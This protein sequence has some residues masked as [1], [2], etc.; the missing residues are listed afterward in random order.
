MLAAVDNPSNA[1]EWALAEM[2]NN[3]ELL[4]MVVEDIDR[5]V[6]RERF[7]QETDIL[8]LNYT[9]ARIR[10]AMRLHHVVPFNVPHIALAETTI[11]G[12]RVPKGSHVL[13]SR[14]DNPNVWDKAKRFKPERHMRGDVDVV[15]TESELRF[16][17][18]STGRRGCI[19]ISLGTAMSIML[20][21]R[22]M[23]GFTWTKPYEVTNIDLRESKDNLYMEIPL[24][25][26]AEPRLPVHLYHCRRA[27]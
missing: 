7:V 26:H 13:L 24:V 2:V 12:Y 4:L 6:S 21:G 19:A 16:I 23:Q 20:F 8:Q 18:I 10:K 17:S 27:N 5:V 25:L 9:K 15:L 14:I 1:V 3:L 11:A 22:L